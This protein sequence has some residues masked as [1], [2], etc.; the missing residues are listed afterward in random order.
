MK[1]RKA[2]FVGG[3]LLLFCV[4]AVVLVKLYPTL[5]LYYM[6]EQTG[7]DVITVVNS[8]G[9]VSHTL[10]IENYT[11]PTVPPE[12]LQEG[13]QGTSYSLDLGT[14]GSLEYTIHNLQF[15]DTLEDANLPED[16]LAVEESLEK[17]SQSCQ[18]LVGEF[19]VT[20][21]GAVPDYEMNDGTMGFLVDIN[22]TETQEDPEHY[23]IPGEV[24]LYFSSHQPITETSTD[25]FGFTLKDG[26]SLDFQLAWLIP[27]QAIEDQ[28]AYLYVGTMDLGYTFDIFDSSFQGDAS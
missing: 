4:A 22:A 13:G 9:E 25:Y 7:Q 20:S 2:L 16:E 8:E 28:R 14:G 6:A 18:I 27:N 23:R 10:G 17:I 21:H 15:Y 5:E 11:E 1:N 24:L 12:T 3:A 19:T 26:E